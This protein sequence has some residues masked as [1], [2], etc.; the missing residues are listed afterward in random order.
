MSRQAFLDRLA[1]RPVLAD[2]AMGTLLYGRGVSFD[3]SFEALNE[4][5]PELV[6]GVHRAYLEAGAELIETN[7]FGANEL[8]LSEHGLENRVREMNLAGARLARA[9]ADAAGGMWVGGSVGPLGVPLSPI[10]ALP[11][12]RAKALFAEQIRALADGGVD[13]IVIETMRYLGEALVA[14]EAAREVCDLPVIALVTFGEDGL[15]ATGRRPEEVARALDGAGADVIG[16]NCSTGPA[17]ALDVAS[18]MAA[19]TD[20]PLCAMPNAGLPAVTHG[21]YIYTASATYT[22]E[23]AA[24]MLGL[25]VRI[26]G[27]CC[28]TTPEHTSAM[29]DA[30]RG[31]SASAPRI[32][33]PVAET[34]GAA[35][36]VSTLRG[37][38]SLERAL[39]ERFVVT[40]E[41]DPPRGF[42]MA[43]LLP[44]L[45]RL[46]DCGYVDAIDVADN[47][48]A[49]ARMSA[50]VMCALVQSQ[51]GLD[52]VLHVGCRHRNLV[53][54]HSDLLGAHALGVRNIFVVMGDLPANGDYPDAT[55]NNDITASGLIRLL[56]GF[57]AGTGLNGQPLGEPTAFH[58]GCAFN[59]DAPDPERE[60]RVLDRKIAAGARFALTQ[61]VYDPR[62]VETVLS[63][64]GGRFPIPLLVGVLPLW[65]Q[66]HARF[67]HHEVPGIR[68]PEAVLARMEATGE[69][70]RDTGVAIAREMLSALDGAI[71]GAYFMPPFGRYELVE[72]ILSTIRAPMR[73]VR[74]ESRSAGADGP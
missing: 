9:E 74:A 69:A 19:V 21:R 30:I 47:P 20:R 53:A 61:P 23:M 59:F 62:T 48:R 3:R 70:G 68:V 6:C 49:Q 46:R 44:S 10:G 4:T 13:A 11:A 55:V 58:A 39:Q 1:E 17:M 24:E 8:R 42:H 16:T 56:S 72:E 37:P 34:K 65:N 52:T 63:R 57:N 73:P 26:V 31:Q 2:G 66:R 43:E 54:V 18:R 28:G 15:T 71:Q 67:L 27:G 41:V 50:L 40:V 33:F 25:G 51:L 14:L 32:A 36:G 5:D 29:R 12:T 60:R 7:T 45:R 22:A 35:R 38:T 64:F